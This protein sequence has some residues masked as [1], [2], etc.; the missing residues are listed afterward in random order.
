MNEVSPIQTL[1]TELQRQLETKHDVIAD[2]RRVTLGENEAGDGHALLIDMPNGVEEFG[3]T[4]NAHHQIS[5][6]VGIPWKTYERLLG[7]QPDLLDHLMNGLFSRE[8]SKRL[9]RT[10]DGKVRAFLSDRYRVYA[11]KGDQRFVLADTSEN[12]LGV[13]LTTLHRE[14]EL[15]GY[16]VGILDRQ[17][18]AWIINPW[19]KP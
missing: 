14:G 17:E 6:S 18:R 12:G 1:A 5:D 16:A 7:T 13:C 3:V 8:N 11:V 19:S 9:V 15:L 2:T 4:R 10:L